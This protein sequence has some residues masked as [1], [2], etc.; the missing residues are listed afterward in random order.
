MRALLVVALLAAS[1]SGE[2]RIHGFIASGPGELHGTVVDA[3]GKPVAGAQ[4][5]V[6]DKVTTTARDGT[7][8]ARLPATEST[9]VYVD[10]D[11]QIT[12][13]LASGDGDVV[14]VH[15]I[16]PPAVPAKPK[17][18]TDVILDYTDDASD[19]DVWTRAWL[20]LDVSERGDVTEL[21]VLRDPGHG[22]LPL[23]ERA[24]FA[25]KFEPALDRS[26]H[27]VQTTVVWSYEW[28]SYW[29][30]L[31]NHYS[32]KRLPP[33]ADMPRCTGLRHRDCSAPDLQKV[34]TQPWVTPVTSK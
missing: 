28:P 25:L 11:V 26:K 31:A 30:M 1:A 13:A 18:R 9:L 24:A 21:K 3:D 2:P 4:V 5:H 32:I 10:G 8:K 17:A 27:P 16:L 34:L 23:A 14:E 20:L 22:L 15:E 33:E 7:Y 12:G 29:W 19:A 6:G